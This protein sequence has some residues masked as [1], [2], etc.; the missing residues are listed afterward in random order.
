MHYLKP[1][2]I[3]HDPNIWMHATLMVSKSHR[4]FFV[5][6]ITERTPD[7]VYTAHARALLRECFTFL[8][9]SWTTHAY[10]TNASSCLLCSRMKRTCMLVR[11]GCSFTRRSPARKS[12]RS[13]ATQQF[14]YTTDPCTAVLRIRIRIILPDP[15][16]HPTI[17]MYRKN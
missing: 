11:K 15:Y 9:L 3:L 6:I 17:D 12:I 10:F 7:S 1:F 14:D 2:Y 16:P 8:L 5:E 4:R 13:S